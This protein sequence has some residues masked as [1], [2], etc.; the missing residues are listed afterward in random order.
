MQTNS[1][2]PFLSWQLKFLSTDF[3]S[4][5][6][7]CANAASS[8]SKYRMFGHRQNPAEMKISFKIQY[9]DRRQTWYWDS[10]NM[11][12]PEAMELYG[13]WVH[14]WVLCPSKKEIVTSKKK[15]EHHKPQNSSR[16]FQGHAPV[17]FLL[18]LCLSRKKQKPL[19][20]KMDRK[21]GFC[22]IY[23]WHVEWLTA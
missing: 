18:F 15:R 16:P 20:L 2:H 4:F 13:T 21:H 5:W 22:W 10:L 19:N 9:G 8:L 14:H 12:E 23:K 11:L 7:V 17:L 1:A 3:W 6:N